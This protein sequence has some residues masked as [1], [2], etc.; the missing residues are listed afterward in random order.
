ME[1]ILSTVYKAKG[2]KEKEWKITRA[3]SAKH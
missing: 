1:K 3:Y 2:P